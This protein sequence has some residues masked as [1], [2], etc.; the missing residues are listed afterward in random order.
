M[1][2]A[3]KNMIVRK[4]SNRIRRS[5]FIKLSALKTVFGQED[6]SLELYPASGLK[7]WIADHFP[8]FSVI[9]NNG[10]ETLRMADDRV[11]KA[12]M[13]LENEILQKG[14]I[15]M[16]TIPNLLNN[17]PENINYK[18]LADGMRLGEWIQA[19]FPDF[20]VSEDN[21][22][23]SHGKEDD[24]I[25]VPVPKPASKPVP[26]KSELAEIQQ[27]HVSAYMNWW[28]VNIKKLRLFN[29]ELTED[30][31][32]TSIAL[33]MSKILLGM[34]SFLIDGMEEEEPRLAFE[35]GLKKS[36]SDESIYCILVPN[37]KNLDGSKQTFAQGGFCCADDGT[38]LGCWVKEHLKSAV[39]RV[40]C[41]VLDEKAGEV[42]EKMEQLAPVLQQYLDCLGSGKIPGEAIAGRIAAFEADCVKLRQLYYGVLQ[43][44]YPEES[45]IRQ[46]RELADGKNILLEQAGKAIS[47]FSEIA[48]KTHEFFVLYSVV[49]EQDISTPRRDQERM[50]SV[51]AGIHEAVDYGVLLSMLGY[52]KD[53]RDVMA[54]KSIVD[55]GV[56][57][58]IERVTSHF[59]EFTSERIAAKILVGT[60]P[61]EREYL[62]GLDAVESRVRE[63]RA[64]F[65]DTD[66]GGGETVERPDPEELLYKI[67]TIGRDLYAIHKITKC[68]CEN[69]VAKMLVFGEREALRD[70]FAENP[71]D[72]FCTEAGMAVLKQGDLPADMTFRAAAERLYRVIGNDGGLAECY[73]IMGLLFDEEKSFHAL[74]ELYR[75]EGK[76]EA[77]MYLFHN[78][79]S[80]N[81]T[82]L[83]EQ[84]AYLGILCESD[85]SAARVYLS[86]HCFLMYQP[87]VISQC[88]LLPDQI[89]DPEEKQKFAE[90][91]ECF[92]SA[93]EMNDFE[94]A[95]CEGDTDRIREFVLQ[96]AKLSE[97]GYS[98]EEAARI[99]KA[100]STKEDSPFGEGDTA[101]NIGRRFY[102]YQKN[103]HSLA[104]YYMWKGIA[105][106]RDVPAAELMVLLAEEGRWDECCKLYECFRAKYS[107]N[108]SCR[109]LYLLA[110]IKEDPVS[111]MD[112]I[113]A[114]LQ[115]CL[116]FMAGT[117]TWVS[118]AV[119][120]QESSEDREVS[121]FY[122]RIRRLSLLLNDPLL[123]SIIC[124]ERSL[125]EYANSEAA[126]KL[127]VRDPFA[128]S[129]AGVYQ[130]EAYPHGMDACSIAG[131]IYAMAGNYQ[132]AAEMFAKFA[133][134]DLQAVHL[135]RDIYLDT[136]DESAL[137][138]LM[139]EYPALRDENEGLYLDLL[140][141]REN[142]LKFAS[143]CAVKENSW[144]RMMQLF[145]AKL[146]TV[147]DHDRIPMPQIT[148][149]DDAKSEA[150]W[151]Q[152]WGAL[153]IHTLYECGRQE[154]VNRI[155]IQLFDQ[156]IRVFDADVIRTIVTGEGSLSETSLL[157]IQRQAVE[158]HHPEL[159][160][161]LYH[162]L[163]VGE[164]E[165]LSAAFLSQVTERLPD[166]TLEELRRLRVIYG[167]A[168]K[169][170]EGEIDLLEIRQ[171]L[172][173]DAGDAEEKGDR[174]GRILSD[175]PQDEAQVL[176]LLPLLKDVRIL[177]NPHVYHSL[178]SLAGTDGLAKELV[179]F[180]HSLGN[181]RE[182]TGHAELQRCVYT[183][184][185]DTLM[186]GAFPEEIL[187]SA[188]ERCI[189]HVRAYHT[190]EGLLC[191][192]FLKCE[193]NQTNHAEYILRMLVEYPLDNMD[194]RTGG[195]INQLLKT[196]W[197][198]NIPSYFDLFKKVLTELRMDEIFE[199]MKF[200]SSVSPKLQP[201]AAEAAADTS[202][203]R[204]LSEDDSNELIRKLY[205]NLGN[206]EVWEQSVSLPIQDNPVAYSKL[207]YINSI[208]NADG[209]E[210]CASYCEKYEQKELLL[211]TL[212]NWA[213]AKEDQ[214]V[215]NCRKYM[216]H[217][218]TE[219]PEYLSCLGNDAKMPEL[220][221][222]VCV[223]YKGSEP[224][225]SLI[226]A[227][228]L[229]AEKSGNAEALNYGI[230]FYKS[231]I[232]GK[233]CNLGVVL[234]ANLMADGR[235]SEAGEI[236]GQL[237]D[238]LNPMNYKELVDE[239][240]R[241]D[242]D[243]L[244]EWADNTENRMM[245]RLIMPDGNMPSIQQ[246]NEIT[247]AGIVNGQVKETVHVI[248]HILSM[249]KNDY[250]AYHALFHLCCTDPAGFIPELHR[251]LRE[252]VRLRP[253]KGAA[254]YYRRRQQD[255]A[256]MLATLDALC[257]VN[258]WTGQ[259]EDYDFSKDTGEYYLF[260]A[261]SD[262][263]YAKGAAISEKRRE[264]ADSFM[265]RSQKQIRMLT[266]AYLGAIT[267]NW[268]PLILH[269]WKED[270]EDI[271]FEIRVQA[272]PGN[273]GGLIRSLFGVLLETPEEERK[274]L[275]DWLRQMAVGGSRETNQEIEF[276]IRFYR[277]GCFA[278]CEQQT[279]FGS[280]EKILRHPFEDYSMSEKW[281]K[282]YIDSA[283]KKKTDTD[284]LFA[285]VWMIGALVKHPYFQAQLLKKADS[286]FE[287]GNDAY[288]S[289]FYS[290]LNLLSRGLELYPD[291]FGRP[292]YKKALNTTD[293]IR[294]RELYEARYRITAAFSND[295]AVRE[296]I[297]RRDF[298]T[299]SCLNMILTLLYSPRC[300]EV[301]RLS[302]FFGKG[303][304]KL[305]E[306]ILTAFDPS[307]QDEEKLELIGNRANEVE[308][309]YF[310]YVVKYP[311]NP[312]NRD[313][314]ITESYAL[315]NS[316]VREQYNT[317]YLQSVRALAGNSAISGNRPRKLLLLESRRPDPKA[318][319][320][321]D[322]SLWDLP[323]EEAIR[324]KV[325]TEEEIPAFA[326]GILPARYE[327]DLADVLIRH[328]KI[329]NLA[330]N[331]QDKLQLSQII[332]QHY[333]ADRPS[334]EEL[335]N[336]L[337]LYGC[338]CYYAALAEGNYAGAHQIL[339][340]LVRILKYRDPSGE[341]AEEA[342]RT[343]QEG[344]LILVKS[345]G[346]LKSLLDCYGENRG[347]L[348][349]V[350]GLIADGLIG[351][352]V[353]QIFSVLDG[354]RNCYMSTAQENQEVL[355]E[356]LSVNYLRLEEIETN[357]W[358]EMKNKVQKLINDEI[359]ELD[360]RPVLS[361][362]I[363][364]Q[365]SQRY[366]G[367]LFGEVHNIGKIDAE[368]II[369]QAAYSD[370][371]S[372]NQYILK[373]LS[374]GGKAVFELD[375]STDHT[376][377]QLE[378]VVTAGFHYADKTLSSTVC[379]GTL[380]LEEGA[381][382]D[383]PTGLLTAYADG[384][385]FKV[386][387]ETGEIYSPDFVGRRNETAMLR[388]LVAGDS[389]ED[390]RSAL[391]YGVRR[392]GKT[393]LLNYL[394]AYI[395]EKKGHIIC[396]KTDCQSIPA[397]EP[398]QYVFIERVIDTVERKLPALKTE[399]AWEE[400]KHTW[401]LGY[402]C[403][404]R[405]PEKLSLFYLDVKELIGE[406]GLFL[407]IDEIDRLFERVEQSQMKYHR[408]LD[409]LFGSVSE[410]LNSYACRKAVHL[411][412]CG[413]NW[414]IRYN[415]KGDRKN[416]LFQR[417]GKQVL[418]VGKLPENDAKELLYLPYRPYPQL[419]ITEEAVKWIWDYAG[420]LVW[421]TK[422][423]GE[424]AVE[425]AKE[426]GRYVVYPSD[427]RQSIPKVITD[428][429]CKQ[430]YE[431]C[432]EGEERDLVDAM[433]SLAAKKDAYVHLNQLSELMSISRVEIQRVVKVLTGL[434][435]LSVH[436]IDS[437]L[438]KFELDIYRR[439][440][441]TNSSKYGQVPEEPDIFQ[442]R[443]PET[444]SAES[445]PV[446]A[447]TSD[448][449][450]WYDF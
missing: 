324:E 319:E 137:L 436:P 231:E 188:E 69:T 367:S 215:E 84:A 39:H 55:E 233:N 349:Y 110:R 347:L 267:G 160:L 50:A 237:K 430:F 320:Q 368:E 315:T 310:C 418:E 385:M 246:L 253:S 64:A 36:G 226:R 192:Y 59:V 387:E 355:R 251:C 126:K 67:N 174:I 327:G 178:V 16:S 234:A 392:T 288:A 390:Y 44:P 268:K 116:A 230:E 308:K 141:K 189:S 173:E 343:V 123:R 176:P 321:K 350:R 311:Y 217:R 274:E 313:G 190:V 140:F 56:M 450:E 410:I 157:S 83:K 300:D 216:E 333:L 129:I 445:R 243:E 104:E 409:S 152:A 3:E 394:E 122:S 31:A 153:L 263:T 432:E 86:E 179:L 427:V 85:P 444:G 272:D 238:V 68:L 203:T 329:Q 212:L 245:L 228:L 14:K 423:L 302:R 284:L 358:M 77:Y 434:K 399:N 161:Y 139:Q 155:L 382:P 18:L 293:R 175:F 220:V 338:D 109:H 422:L 317:E 437:Q 449:S 332:C 269:A 287:K 378:Y 276:V 21:L 7:K 448:D 180:F 401:S 147:A 1:T 148:N 357:R 395:R 73:D 202:Q 115:E 345:S 124:L 8:E 30:M 289:V 193:R 108:G 118:D 239:L 177:T 166:F 312:R 70:Y 22:W 241:K 96:E 158:T 6:I 380:F 336:A 260:H 391:M 255:Y 33:Q 114:N 20:K 154:D 426:N 224:G 236:L 214:T 219:N 232:F 413:S 270:K 78:Y 295:R 72:P 43:R 23:L 383:Y 183:L 428:L 261:Y 54:A 25:P 314:A 143:E 254:S 17:S 340:D 447:E 87:E 45:T 90:R 38:D 113:R 207:L 264:V 82:S 415:L 28:N 384:I 318:F 419:I 412:I 362:E 366:Y 424:E 244:R 341:G 278:R 381:E 159:A 163:G 282:L 222:A 429:W 4:L 135:L 435:I 130:A 307:V 172:S 76:K 328:G 344:L 354:L 182:L 27:M 95:V 98:E 433:Q 360:Q 128:S 304:R 201:G 351:A 187:D 389:F 363:L 63:C 111:A 348:Q 353:A 102:R 62:S 200:A 407:I 42:G 359:N 92:A 79:A 250:G 71:T 65:E 46:I 35:T 374:P 275:L 265:N 365:G 89:L 19:V 259:I 100:C 15:L 106:N 352:C 150:A 133:V 41:S 440:F 5:G 303:N 138:S 47:D 446:V 13:I 369:I 119:S 279:E 196:T 165:G 393:S 290:A 145:I 199:Y 375:Y 221:K 258:Q 306:D 273:H 206:P 210:G 37:P 205:S 57:E 386:D 443:Q 61:E 167:D 396:V 208:Y 91:L 291:V 277:E 181:E 398:I 442:I 132:N 296:K 252:L 121:A 66:A 292:D 164:L 379:K 49:A 404:D 134:P 105:D 10:Y 60:Q 211:Q 416:Q 335:N 146:K 305:A 75:H 169:N 170:L 186:R 323:A 339:F 420:G 209:C 184:Y 405:Q 185:T 2:E 81:H 364:N 195:R 107:Q 40:P 299:W 149:P 417:F 322:P 406:Y 225:H 94:Q 285:M 281:E 438:Y 283:L 242:T 247:D 88:L 9:G 53:L 431:G 388:S 439:Y 191:L 213:N 26:Q 402:F 97:L 326:R 131:R 257:I 142:Y 151:Y 411:V 331:M 421:H 120:G 218:L 342:R 294:C 11:A 235:I 194:S 144:G 377:E 370:G 29:E 262:K 103:K 248:G 330:A 361:F 356:E 117:Q 298:H 286:Y 12:W 51:S 256:Y 197:G 162:V 334:G 156:W 99:R 280:L 400:L 204:M 425:R 346:D 325:M 32:K 373:K 136:G 171:I 301:L 249:F 414:L 408:N 376:C 403:A 127:G 101:V 397:N 229:I 337:L 441:R 74:L 297:K 223:R 112:Y 52:Y 198:Y 58:K 80:E 48:G 316:D 266:E 271:S 372:S 24:A 34:D 93:G 240:A 125:R 309:A 168:V 227:S 371:S